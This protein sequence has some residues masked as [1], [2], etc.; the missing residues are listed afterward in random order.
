MT[1]EAKRELQASAA[2]GRH[3]DLDKRGRLMEVT[4]SP[5]SI[6]RREALI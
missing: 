6:I 2:P 4:L 1:R 5:R 3:G